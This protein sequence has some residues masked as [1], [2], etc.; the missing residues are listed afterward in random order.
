MKT[1]FNRNVMVTLL[2]ISTSAYVGCE[3]KTQMDSGPVVL[4]N[5]IPTM[6]NGMDQTKVAEPTNQAPTLPPAID[7]KRV[8]PDEN[9]AIAGTNAI[10]GGINRLRIQ[11]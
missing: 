4:S 7:L 10:P 1:K 6:T 2:V 8:A 3:K 11:N 5:S 9:P